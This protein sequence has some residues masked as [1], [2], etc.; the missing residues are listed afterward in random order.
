MQKSLLFI[1]SFLFLNFQVKAQWSK[2]NSNLSAGKEIQNFS[3]VNQ[4]VVW[5]AGSDTLY[6]ENVGSTPY[7]GFTRTTNGG[8]TWTS[9]T[10]NGT[11]V[12]NTY[13]IAGIGAVS[14]LK[15]SVALYGNAGGGGIFTTTNGGV[16]WSKSSGSNYTDADSYPNLIHFFNANDGVSMGDPIGTGSAKDF[17]ILITNNG[18][19]SWTKV[20]GANIAGVPLSGEYGLVGN[21]ST[22]GNSIWFGTNKSRIYYSHDKGETWAVKKATSVAG[23]GSVYRLNFQD[24]QNGFAILLN[25]AGSSIV[26]LSKTTDGGATWANFTGITGLDD[27]FLG[28]FASPSPDFCLSAGGRNFGLSQDFGFSW[29]PFDSLPSTEEISALGFFSDSIGWAGTISSGPGNGGIYKFEIISTGIGQYINNDISFNIYPNPNNGQ[30]TIEINS[31]EKASDILIRD[32]TG[33][34][35]YQKLNLAHGKQFSENINLS[36]QAKGIYFITIR[37]GDKLYTKKLIID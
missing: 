25:A 3:V 26:A 18:G 13:N 24:E 22:V 36:N 8:T 29:A 19:T 34:T 21:Y 32:I 12:L 33:K 17:E 10:V 20:S 37:N 31:S 30:F 14:D 15:A 16:N 11:G 1:F 5:A 2:Q 27:F 28:S 35:I 7:L 9:G 6:I 4:D 23:T